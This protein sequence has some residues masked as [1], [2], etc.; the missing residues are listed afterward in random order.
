MVQAHKFNIPR[1]KCEKAQ[2]PASQ[3]WSPANI[4]LPFC[5]LA[6]IE[7]VYP[8]AVAYGGGGQVDVLLGVGDL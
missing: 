7:P 6:G 8:Q 4:T 2:H 1:Q 5:Q 3:T